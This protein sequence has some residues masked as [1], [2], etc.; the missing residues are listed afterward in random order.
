MDFK[1]FDTYIGNSLYDARVLKRLTQ[2]Q[3]AELI[4]KRLKAIGKR[5][6]GIS[7]QRYATYEKG[8]ISMPEDIYDVVCEI[9]NIDRNDLFNRAIEQLKK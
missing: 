7:R 1:K 8:E 4:S 9:L 6:N 2:P 3:L 5:K